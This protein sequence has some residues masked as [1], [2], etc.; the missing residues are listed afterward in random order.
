M[1]NIFLD[2]STNIF[3][4]PI[5]HRCSDL[6]PKPTWRPRACFSTQPFSCRSPAF[7]EFGAG[8]F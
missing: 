3:Q 2:G 1:L 6:F 4:G 8:Q 5:V 7:G